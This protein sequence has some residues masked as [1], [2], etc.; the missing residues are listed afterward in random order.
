MDALDDFPHRLGEFRRVILILRIADEIEQ[1]IKHRREPFP[2]IGRRRAEI[3]Q[4]LIIL[5]VSDDKQQIKNNVFF[6]EL[7]RLAGKHKLLRRRERLAR[8]AIPEINARGGVR[9]V[10]VWLRAQGAALPQSIDN[11]SEPKKCGGTS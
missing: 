8:P 4:H 2:Q 3:A 6:N 10:H 7:M 9:R 1:G 5:R 11:F